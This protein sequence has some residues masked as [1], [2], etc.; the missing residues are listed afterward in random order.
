MTEAA[1]SV[2]SMVDRPLHT[3]ITTSWTETWSVELDGPVLDNLD[4]AERSVPVTAGGG[5]QW[6]VIDRRSDS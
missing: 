6:G 2:A 3:A 4:E 5:G 1:A